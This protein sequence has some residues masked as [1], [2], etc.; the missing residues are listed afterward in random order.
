V[1][2]CFCHLQY[3][4]LGLIQRSLVP[5]SVRI[6][7]VVGHMQCAFCTHIVQC[8][9]AY[10][11]YVIYR[12]SHIRSRSV[13]QHRLGLDRSCTTCASILGRAVHYSVAALATWHHVATSTVN[14]LVLVSP[15]GT[16]QCTVRSRVRHLSDS[17][18]GTQQPFVSASRCRT[19]LIY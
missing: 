7:S 17:S 1:R 9:R 19:C 11:P 12:C 18:L 2:R 10:L 3:R 13:C 16:R 5:L 8:L 4:I 14:P 15:R 6:T